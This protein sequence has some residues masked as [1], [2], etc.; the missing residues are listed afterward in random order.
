MGAEILRTTLVFTLSL[1][2][3]GIL[4][5]VKMHQDMFKLQQITVVGVIAFLLRSLS[6][7]GLVGR[8]SLMSRKARHCLTG[9]LDVF[10]TFGKLKGLLVKPRSICVLLFC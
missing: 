8:T 5:V 6:T 7:L 9:F 2:L 1:H 10:Q 3:F 4:M